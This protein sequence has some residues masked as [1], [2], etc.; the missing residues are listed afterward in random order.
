MKMRVTEDDFLGIVDYLIR[1]RKLFKKVHSINKVLSG[2][3]TTRMIQTEKGKF[4]LKIF[5]EPFPSDKNFFHLQNEII[6]QRIIKNFGFPVKKYLFIE[7]MPNS[8]TRFPFTVSEYVLGKNLENISKDEMTFIIPQI[9]ESLFNLHSMSISRSFGYLTKEHFFGPNF[10]FEE[11]E[12]Y[13]LKEDIQRDKIDFSDEEKR[14][15][16]LAIK[17]LR[18]NEFF[19]LCHWDITG[20]NIIYDGSLAKLIDWGYSH[21]TDPAS[22]IAGV[23]FLMAELNLAKQL[24][25][26]ITDLQERYLRLGFDIFRT[27]PFYLG[28]RYIEVGRIKGMSYIRKAKNILGASV[29]SLDEFVELILSLSSR[30]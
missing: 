20:R 15:L 27:L 3:S 17:S 14:N 6:V 5:W 11:F 13:Y 19:C 23:L 2:S 22:D 10:P 7:L 8:L 21:Y 12:S 30:G 24:R 18:K 16:N 9:I 1:N 28:Q 26:N 4:L 29:K 25:E